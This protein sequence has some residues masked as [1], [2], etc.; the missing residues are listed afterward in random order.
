M[1]APSFAQG[2]FTSHTV[3]AHVAEGHHVCPAISSSARVTVVTGLKHQKEKRSMEQ[4]RLSAIER[5][6]AQDSRELPR[7]LAPALTL[8]ETGKH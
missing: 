4:R 7:D 1:S 5:F 2:H 3:F 8:V 6:D